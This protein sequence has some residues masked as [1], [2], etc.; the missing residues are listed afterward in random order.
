G[1]MVSASLQGVGPQALADGQTGNLSLTVTTPAARASFAGQ[2]VVVDRL[3]LDGT[4]SLSAAHPLA[5]ARWLSGGDPAGPDIGRATLDG[6]LKLIGGGVTV[7]EAEL[8]LGEARGEGVLSA[9]WDGRRPLLRGTV[10]FED[11]AMAR[12]TA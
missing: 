5:L 1:Q 3:Q 6:R 4:V 12:G 2:A 11:T 8:G 7:S 10:D 9:Q